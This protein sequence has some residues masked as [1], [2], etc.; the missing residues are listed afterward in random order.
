MTMGQKAIDFLSA[1][2]FYPGIMVRMN[3]LSHEESHLEITPFV[4]GNS[5]IA[6]VRATG[7]AKNTIVGCQ[8]MTTRS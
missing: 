7:V 5:V 2:I 6:A 1:E 3:R 4:W 8:W